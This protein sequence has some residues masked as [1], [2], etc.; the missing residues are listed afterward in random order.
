MKLVQFG[1]PILR[2]T[3][4]RLTK[5]EILAPETQE[6]IR[7]MRDHLNSNKKYGIGLAAPQVGK[8][9]AL[10][11]IEIK[12]TPYRPEAIRAS[13][14]M[15]NP[16]IVMAHGRRAPMWEGCMSFGTS[17]VNFPYAQAVRYKKIRLRYLDEQAKQ[18]ERDFDGLLAH[19]IQHEADHLEGILFVDRVKD[20]RSYVMKA[21][22]MKR[23]KGG[24]K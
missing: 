9:I 19:A 4:R 2:R 6:L 1:N 24:A 7:A 16:E 8:D 14:V 18:H 23:I 20:T 13:L 5:A 21:E 22:Y 12:P 17:R 3:A 10:S 15:I 11:V